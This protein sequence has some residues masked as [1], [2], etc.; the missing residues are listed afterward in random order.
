MGDLLGSLIRGNQKRTI[1][2]R[3]GWVITNGIRAIAQPEIGR[4]MHKPVRDA[5][6]HLLGRQEWGDPMRVASGEARS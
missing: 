1:L 2:C 5:S 6:G 4:S 3:L